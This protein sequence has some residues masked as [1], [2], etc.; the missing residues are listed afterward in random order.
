M[1]RKKA[2]SKIT[3]EGVE[4]VDVEA[5]G[6]GRLPDMAIKVIKPIVA[7]VAQNDQTKA[8]HRALTAR[9]ESENAQATKLFEKFKDHFTQLPNGNWL[10]HV[11][12]TRLEMAHP[13][14]LK[15]KMKVLVDE[16]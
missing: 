12:G 3:E 1:A 5:S 15:P 9:L 7:L 16:E 14:D 13:G 6:Q 10:Y 2:E 4:S 11:P 8:E